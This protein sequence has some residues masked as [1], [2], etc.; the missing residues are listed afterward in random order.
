M[1]SALL[2]CSF[3]AQWPL[4]ERRDDEDCN[5]VCDRVVSH[6]LGVLH[7]CARDCDQA[8]CLFPL[9][10]DRELILSVP[11]GAAD[12]FVWDQRDLDGLVCLR[13]APPPPPGSL[14]QMLLRANKRL[15]VAMRWRAE[16][17]QSAEMRAPR[18]D[19]LR[20]HTRGGP[21]GV[22]W[23]PSAGRRSCC[24]LSGLGD[25]RTGRGDKIGIE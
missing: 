25:L 22:F 18:A 15:L 10:S 9:S 11:R 21:T 4:L 8:R 3:F 13:C 6:R 5:T 23:S 12:S 17:V 7:N 24:G 20:T 16:G 1:M 19:R 14:R 2:A